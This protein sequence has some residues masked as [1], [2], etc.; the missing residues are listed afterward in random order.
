MARLE[1]L[2][3]EVG[4]ESSPITKYYALITI[5][6]VGEALNFLDKDTHGQ[7]ADDV[8]GAERDAPGLLAELLY[9]DVPTHLLS[10]M[11]EIYEGLTEDEIESV[12]QYLY[13][14]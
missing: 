9:L 3:E 8:E 14:I 12:L 1:E 5:A 4:I 13:Q 6:N 2:V 11:M 7:T 10:Y